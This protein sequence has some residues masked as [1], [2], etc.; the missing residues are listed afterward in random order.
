VIG[1]AAKLAQHRGV[2]LAGALMGLLGS[3]LAYQG[4]PANSGICISCFL[5]NAAG[6]VGLHPNPR[7][8]Y[9]RPELLGFFL[10]SFVA[11]VAARE[12]RP[13]WSGAGLNLFGFGFLMMVG[14]AVFIGCPIKAVLRLAAGDLTSLPG[15][16]G[17]VAGVWAG[18]SLLRTGDPT[19]G[20]RRLTASPTIPLGAVLLAVSLTALV[21]LPGALRE[22]RGGGGSLHAA[23]ALSL[24]AGLALGIACQRSRFCITGSIRDFLLTRSAWPAAALGAAIVA[25]LLANFFTGQFSVGYYGQPGTHLDAMWSVLGM[26]LVGVVAVI[27]G[28]C[29]FR[30]IVRAGEGDLDA[31]TVFLGMISGAALV[32]VWGLGATTAGVPAGGK[33]AVLLGLAAISFLALHRGEESI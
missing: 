11:A 10:G 27:A 16:G 17:L 12:F 9:M 23:P 4:N 18:L 13:R 5:E 6:A 33:V 31:L 24:T 28:G 25:A 21:F 7:M 29:P 15:L 2:L 22:S 19:G 1:P 3:V 26:G 8:Q 20:G 32:Q 14:S 30:Q